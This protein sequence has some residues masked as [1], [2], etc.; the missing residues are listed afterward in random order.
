MIRPRPRWNTERWVLLPGV[1]VERS[2]PSVWPAF[3]PHHY[4]HN[5]NGCSICYIAVDA[6]GDLLGF[7]SAI[8]QPS[9]SG[10]YWR[11]HRLVVI[12]GHRGRGIGSALSHWL[13]EQSL[14]SGHRY[15]SRTRNK[16]VAAARDASSLWR[17]VRH[18]EIRHDGHS[19]MRQIDIQLA[20][21]TGHE[22]VG[23]SN[24]FRLRCQ[25]CGLLFT[26]ARRHAKH[27]SGAC[28][29]AAHRDARRSAQQPP[30]LAVR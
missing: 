20:H 25:R 17:R 3:A 30:E 5:L 11:E 13:G 16:R 19:R 12:P 6:K 4:L 14:A 10:G 18:T 27:C 9:R 21:S 29:V 26:A 1:W 24:T 2:D 28:R 22:Y 23:R 7:V 8:P 15:F